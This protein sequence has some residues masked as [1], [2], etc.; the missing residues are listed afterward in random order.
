MGNV[1]SGEGKGTDEC[2]GTDGEVQRKTKNGK[3]GEEIMDSFDRLM[4]SI[5]LVG[6]A[7]LVA[8]NLFITMDVRE[9]LNTIIKVEVR[10]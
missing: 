1:V 9:R 4:I 6:I 7:I 3:E 2:C 5:M 8:T 10:K